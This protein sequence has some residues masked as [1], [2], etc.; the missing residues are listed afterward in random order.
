MHSVLQCFTPNNNLLSW[1]TKMQRLIWAGHRGLLGTFRCVLLAVN[2]SSV[3][4]IKTVHKFSREK[5]ECTFH[6]LTLP[7]WE[8]TA[9]YSG[10][11]CIVVLDGTQ[12]LIL[13]RPWL[14][15]EMSEEFF[16]FPVIL[17][18]TAV[19][20]PS[21]QSLIGCLGALQHLLNEDGTITQFLSIQSHLGS[22]RRISRG[23]ISF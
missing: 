10:L 5:S 15:Q 14:H 16:P 21:F 9:D 1:V 18:F 8:D 13:A 23:I 20:M 7:H 3:Q 6:P 19:L 2:C 17:L 22:Y 12:G 11:H 4:A